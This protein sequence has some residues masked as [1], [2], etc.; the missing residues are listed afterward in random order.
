MTE[1]LVKPASEAPFPPPFPES[2]PSIPEDKKPKVID[3]R[4]GGKEE[5]KP[6]PPPMPP[7]GFTK[8]LKDMYGYIGMSVTMISPNVGETILLQAEKCAESVNELA[9]TNPSVR[10]VIQG[11][12]TT[13]A[14]GAVIAAHAPI[15]M[16]I[17]FNH[18]E[19]GR[20]LMMSSQQNMEDSQHD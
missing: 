3:F 6:P 10:R 16:A 11:L 8:A 18:T 17:F 20:D 13:S 9:R 4:K 12:V 2:K 1:P 14:W 15:A 19:R 5:K 7:G